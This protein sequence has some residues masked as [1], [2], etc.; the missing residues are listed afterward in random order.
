MLQWS[1]LDTLLFCSQQPSLQL[2]ARLKTLCTDGDLRSEC[3]IC[4]VFARHE[5]PFRPNKNVQ[6]G[7]F[8]FKPTFVDKYTF[9]FMFDYE[10]SNV[11]SCGET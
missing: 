7:E 8:Y 1:Q 9:F 4:T 3:G 11:Q 10:S 6:R 5:I 2:A